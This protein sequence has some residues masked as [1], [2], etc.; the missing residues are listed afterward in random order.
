MK[1]KKLIWYWHCHHDIICEPVWS[2]KERVDYIRKDKP[3]NEIKTRLSLFKKVKHLEKLPK[4]FIKVGEK[5][6]E[7]SKKCA[8][9]GKKYYEAREKYKPQL[10]KLHAEECACKE[11]NGKELVFDAG[12]G[13]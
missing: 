7:A 2:Y 1:T 13:K 12:E 11:W 4:E 5:Y 3:K 9:A 8:E 10:E 6:Y